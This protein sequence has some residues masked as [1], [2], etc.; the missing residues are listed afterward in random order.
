MGLRYIDVLIRLNPH[1]PQW[2]GT[3]VYGEPKAQE[4]HHMWNLLRRIKTASNA[5]WFVIGD[6][7][8]TLCQSEH[9][10][11]TKRS[12]RNMANFREVLSECGLFDLGFK[13]PAWTYNN[14]QE[15]QKNVKARLDRGVASSS[16]SDIF[17]EAVVEH[18]CSSRSDHLPLLVRLG[19]R[20]EWRPTNE[21]RIPAFR[22]EYM[23]ERVDSLS[24]SIDISWKKNGEAES[25]EKLGTKLTT[26]QADLRQWAAKDFGSILKDTAAIR[27]ELGNLW[28]D[29]QPSGQ[30]DKIKQLSKDLDELLLR[31]EMMWRQ[32]SR[33]SELKEGDRSTKYFQ[34]K[35]TWR[36]K[37]KNTIAKLK[38]ELGNWITDKKGIE[39]H[40][41]KFFRFIYK[42]P[43]CGA[44]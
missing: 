36:K 21:K 28:R 32:R 4:R 40:A 26:M 38:D 6:F 10:S 1:G 3:F 37:K 35:A 19:P 31:E 17:R 22:Y 12:E 16:W 9:I 23:W 5:P 2:R 42:R 29:P 43:Q 41:T 13:G 24:S 33:V 15:G 27:K 8:E 7:N 34:R 44:S 39:D 25:L 11:A 14:K 20:L 18:I 30:Q